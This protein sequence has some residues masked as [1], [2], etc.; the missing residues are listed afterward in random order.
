MN[1]LASW[2]ADLVGNQCYNFRSR[3]CIRRAFV[4]GLLVGSIWRD[5][6]DTSHSL[7]KCYVMLQLSFP[8]LYQ[9]TIFCW[10]AGR[11]G[12]KRL[13]GYQSQML[14]VSFLLFCLALMVPYIVYT[15]QFRINEMQYYNKDIRW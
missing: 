15:I 5:L 4:A 10:F 2:F 6:V 1:A 13:C 9:E 12:M 7:T 8:S 11:F 3:A 14:Q